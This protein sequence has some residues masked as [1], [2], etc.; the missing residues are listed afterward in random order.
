VLNEPIN[1]TDNAEA[2]QEFFAEIKKVD[3][4]PVPKLTYNENDARVM[5]E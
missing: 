3:D 1:D 5:R 4:E 2:W